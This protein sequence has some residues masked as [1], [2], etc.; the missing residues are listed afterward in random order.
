MCGIIRDLDKYANI[1]GG[2]TVPT[3]FFG[4][5]TPSLMPVDVFSK[6][7]ARINSKFHIAE[8]AEI[9][10]ESNPGTIDT[11]KL[12][13]FI[14]AGVNRLSVGVQSLD[15]VRLKYLGRRHD[16]ATAINLL[17]TAA[18]RNIHVS[19]DFIYGVPGDTPEYVSDLCRQINDLGLTHCSMY[20]LT[21]EPGTPL[22][23]QN[24][25]MPTNDAMAEMYDAIGR[26]LNLARY[27]VSNYSRPGHEC[28][29]NQ[30][31]WDG[32]P[33]VGF[34]RGA[35]GRVFV[36][37]AWYE[38]T[39]GDDGIFNKL[40]SHD[41]A[42]EKIITGMRTTRGVYLSDDV[43][44]AI[45]MVF[46]KSVPDMII[47]TSENRICTTDKGRLILDDLLVKLVR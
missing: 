23:A 22:A 32:A 21:I 6:I 8:N 10:L 11:K 31:V 34:G 47:M 16:V 9:T 14:S 5:G 4:G 3:I 42:V 24:P 20:E 45:N 33:Y 12:G 29:H 7:M 13:N 40:S 17:R 15:D 19:G 37:G 28:R 30:N 25:I 35:A 39:G 43:A 27:E 36:D 26:K 41:R 2:A 44:A 38:Q 46:A 18:A 1:I